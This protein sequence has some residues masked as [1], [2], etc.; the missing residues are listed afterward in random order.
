MEKKRKK[1]IPNVFYHYIHYKIWE[2][3]RG[4]EISKKEVKG[5]LAEWRIPKNLRPLILKELEILGLIKNSK[6][7]NIEIE[8]SSFDD[9]QVS[10]FCEDLKIY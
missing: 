8:K 3:S 9:E 1:K 4:Y 7:H 2:K 6:R 10:E 5:Y